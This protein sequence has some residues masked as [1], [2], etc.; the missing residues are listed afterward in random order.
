M[1]DTLDDLIES[2]WTALRPNLIR[3]ALLGRKRVAELVMLTCAEFPDRELADC[4]RGSPHDLEQREQLARRVEARYRATAQ[5]ATA[6][7]PYGFVILVTILTW[8]IAAIVAHIAVR[9]WE[10]HFD[11]A[12]M[13]RQ[14]GWKEA[15]R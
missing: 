14:Y 1:A 5:A 9:W 11:A 2:T 4:E 6:A 13:R 12:G 15:G 7:E 10:R 3:R 8:A